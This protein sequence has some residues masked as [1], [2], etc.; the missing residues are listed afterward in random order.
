MSIEDKKDIV[1]EVVDRLTYNGP[2]F[3]EA[4]NEF[5]AQHPKKYEP[6]YN[7]GKIGET[8]RENRQSESDLLP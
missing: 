5:L 1:Q 4:L 7:I 8:I 3:T 2:E 6:E